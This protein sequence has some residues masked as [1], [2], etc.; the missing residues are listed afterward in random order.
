MMLRSIIAALAMLSLGLLLS[1]CASSRKPTFDLGGMNRVT[2]PFEVSGA[3]LSFTGH[4]TVKGTI[5]GVNGRFII[6]TGA[7]GPLLTMTAVR[8]CGIIACPSR[9]RGADMFGVQF[10]L[11]VATNITIRFT[12]QFSV[13]YAEVLVSPE[14]GDHFGLL[15]YGTLRSAH[16]VMDMEQR[17]ITLTK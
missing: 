8:R 14:E 4:P 9:S 6:D 5:N 3:F 15:D 13:H 17:T 2:I 10:P 11:K 16:A 1:G 12:P 7:P